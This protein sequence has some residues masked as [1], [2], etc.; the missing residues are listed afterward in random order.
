MVAEYDEIHISLWSGTCPQNGGEILLHQGES[1][2]GEKEWPL[3]V[4]KYMTVC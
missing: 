1:N 3:K 4:K 2:T